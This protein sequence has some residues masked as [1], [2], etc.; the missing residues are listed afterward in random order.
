[1]S[2]KI[3]VLQER[4]KRE[5]KK[6]FVILMVCLGIAFCMSG[7]SISVAAEPNE[8]VEEMKNKNIGIDSLKEIDGGLYYDMNTNIVYWWNGVLSDSD[9]FSNSADT[10]PTPYFASNGL[11]Y[12][13]NPETNTLEEIPWGDGQGEVSED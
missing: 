12:K 13:Y 7:C 9:Y 5:M 4:V 6:R 10:T 8:Q 2:A 11:P 1:M 3:G